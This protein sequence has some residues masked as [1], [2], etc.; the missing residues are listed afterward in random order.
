[1]LLQKKDYKRL[2]MSKIPF[3]RREPLLRRIW[4]QL[5]SPVEENKTAGGLHS[6]RQGRDGLEQSETV[7]SPWNEQRILGTCSRRLM[8]GRRCSSAGTTGLAC[9]RPWFQFTALHKLGMGYTVS[10]TYL[11]LSRRKQESQ[12]RVL[13][14]G[15]SVY[16]VNYFSERLVCRRM[17]GKEGKN[18]GRK[19]EETDVEKYG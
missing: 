3:G 7:R 6:Q 15:F 1:M 18:E 14:W 2:K 10:S 12:I 9:I 5:L 4:R 19:G 17:K 13:F 8:W 16:Y 11:A